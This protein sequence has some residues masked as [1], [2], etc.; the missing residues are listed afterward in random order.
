MIM[1]MAI[2][3]DK[4]GLPVAFEDKLTELAKV[5]NINYNTAKSMLY[6]NY[7]SRYQPIRIIKI[8]LED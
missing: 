7:A 4:Y 3:D 8:V 5:L 2:T 1:Y 6:Q